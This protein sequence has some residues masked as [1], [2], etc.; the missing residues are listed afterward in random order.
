MKVY[1]EHT[2]LKATALHFSNILAICPKTRELFKV[3]QS[4]VFIYS[5]HGW[6]MSD[7]GWAEIELLLGTVNGVRVSAPMELDRVTQN[8]AEMFRAIG[9][10]FQDFLARDQTMNRLQMAAW[11]PHKQT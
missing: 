5:L 9:G 7:T 2:D 8:M 1:I 4:L 11:Q 6:P 10:G 3:I